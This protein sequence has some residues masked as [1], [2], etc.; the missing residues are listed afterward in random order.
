MVANREVALTRDGEQKVMEKQL[1]VIDEKS[2][3][4]T[5]GPHECDPPVGH[6]VRLPATKG[7]C[8]LPHFGTTCISQMQ[9]SA[10]G[11]RRTNGDICRHSIDHGN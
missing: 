1:R 8:A 2:L 6:T 7:N 5:R 10:L 3:R 4:D 9:A 11:G